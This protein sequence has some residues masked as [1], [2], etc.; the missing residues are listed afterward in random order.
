M[1]GICVGCYSFE[2]GTRPIRPGV[3]C[4]A[5]RCAVMPHE[6]DRK[7][8]LKPQEYASRDVPEYCERIEDHWA[9]AKLREL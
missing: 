9:A 5:M 1:P 6:W 8:W 2:S 3:Y 4:F 7:G